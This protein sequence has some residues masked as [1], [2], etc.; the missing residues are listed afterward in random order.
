MDLAKL[1]SLGYKPAPPA[2]DADLRSLSAGLGYPLPEQVAA[3]LLASNGYLHEPGAL[4][5]MSDAD[6]IRTIN[7]VVRRDSARHMPLDHLLFIG[8]AGC[9]GILFAVGRRANGTW[10]NDVYAWDPL[11]DSRD[12]VAPS[13]PHLLEWWAT[14]KISV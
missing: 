7:E 4:W 12:W 8:S 10:C 2:S 11:E 1:S 3:A 9:D 13:I 6:S 5:V 14:S